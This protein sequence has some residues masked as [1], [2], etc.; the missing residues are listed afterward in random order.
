MLFQF[1]TARNKTN[2][3]RKTLKIDTEKKTYTTRE[4]HMIPEGI[5]IKTADYRELLNRVQNDPAFTEV[6]YL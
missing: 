6:E 4:A 1:K 2:G 5:E 3:S